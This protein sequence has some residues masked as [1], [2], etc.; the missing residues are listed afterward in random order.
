MTM[1]NFLIIGAMKAGTTALYSYLKQHPEIYMSPVKE[2]NFFAFEGERMN[3]GAPIGS[4]M[5]CECFKSTC[6][7]LSSLILQTSVL[8]ATAREWSD[9][10]QPDGSG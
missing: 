10:H 7:V 6:M 4:S 9:P 1:P 2:P 3:F 5:D 8:R